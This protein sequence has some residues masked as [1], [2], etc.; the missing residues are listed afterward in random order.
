M[1]HQRCQIVNVS[2][3][4][5]SHLS[6]KEEFKYYEQTWGKNSDHGDVYDP[7]RDPFRRVHWTFDKYLKGGGTLEKEETFKRS[8]SW[9]FPR[10]SST[11]LNA[12]YP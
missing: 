8:K 6:I 3:E 5:D 2:R 4:R 11:T 10:S 12:K 1:V 7:Q 9:N